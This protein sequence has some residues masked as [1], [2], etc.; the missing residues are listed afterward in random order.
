[1]SF[2]NIFRIFELEEYRRM[3]IVDDFFENNVFIPKNP[4]ARPKG[5]NEAKLFIAEYCR[6]QRRRE[7]TELFGG[8]KEKTQI[9]ENEKILLDDPETFE[10]D[11]ERLR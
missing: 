6:E 3:L 9:S 10:R 2:G 11:L 7:K 4:V 1:L 5:R 8:V